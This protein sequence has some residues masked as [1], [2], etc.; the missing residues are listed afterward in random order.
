MGF[1]AET[2]EDRWILSRFNRTANDVN[3]ALQTFRFHEA[4]NKIYDFFWGEFCDWYLE[5]IKARLNT[6]GEAAKIACANLVSLFEAALRLLHPV[7]PFITEEIWH[8]MYDGK[9]PSQSIALAAYPQADEAQISLAAETDMAILQDLIVSVRNL[10]AEL[11]VE[12]RE[13]VPAQIFA[14]DSGVRSLMQQNQTA[15][16]RLANVGS[17]QFSETS[18]AKLP[19]TRSTA[20]FDVHVVYEKRIDVAAERDRLKKELEKFDK[21]IASLNRQLNNTEFVAKAPAQVVDKM[22][23]R[24]EELQV[25]RD[26]ARSKLDELDGK[27]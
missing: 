13:K 15:I 24:H 19:S 6:E 9:P 25:L 27:Q 11:K 5:L 14:A 21:E 17:L 7:M 18:L 23:K 10:R 1:H 12:P 2:L 3:D 16:E 22:R 26:K 8:A 4:A 20:R